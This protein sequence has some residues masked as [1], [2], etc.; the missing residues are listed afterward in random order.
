MPLIFVPENK[1][2]PYLLWLA[3]TPQPARLDIF[4]AS[5]LSVT[6]PIW[7]TFPVRNRKSIAVSQK[8]QINK[9]QNIM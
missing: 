1:T 3:I 2:M 8:L 5:I 6:E 4:T 7:F 9:P